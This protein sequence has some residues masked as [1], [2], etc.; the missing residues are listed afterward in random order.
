MHWT[1]SWMMDV[2]FTI[3]NGWLRG[4]RRRRRGRTKV[5]PAKEMRQY[6]G[7]HSEKE[8]EESVLHNGLPA[9]L[10]QAIFICPF[11]YLCVGVPHPV[12]VL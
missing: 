11:V 5:R 6:T 10:F 8:E 1:S 12:A 4:R 7:F 2:A 9:V 3:L